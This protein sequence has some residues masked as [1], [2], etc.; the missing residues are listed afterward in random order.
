METVLTL[1]L[2]GMAHAMASN[3]RQAFEDFSSALPGLMGQ[4]GGTDGAPNKLTHT[5]LAAYI[6]F[7]GRIHG[8]SREPPQ[9]QYRAH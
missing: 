2:R 5:I 9:R 7:L 4:N 8:S 6:D 3:Q 1:G